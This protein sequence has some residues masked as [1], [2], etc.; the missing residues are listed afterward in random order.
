MLKKDKISAGCPVGFYHDPESEEG[1]PGLLA[2]D[3]RFYFSFYNKSN[4]FGLTIVPKLHIF[5][6][7]YGGGV[8]PAISLGMAFSSDLA[9]WSLR[10]EV[11]FDE[12]FSAG[13]AL[14]VSISKLFIKEKK[15]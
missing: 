5:F 9:K 15:K 7:S 10:P 11:G 6:D 13:V 3:P 1:I 4:K 12:F 8:M 2:F 14:N